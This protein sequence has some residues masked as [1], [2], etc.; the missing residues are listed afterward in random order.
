MRTKEQTM[1]QPNEGDLSTTFSTLNVNAMEFVPS[2][3]SSQPS[4]TP[5]PTDEPT[6]DQPS[7]TADVGGDDNDATTVPEPTGTPSEDITTTTATTTELIEDKTPE[8]P[9]EHVVYYDSTR[10]RSILVEFATGTNTNP[11][12]TDFY[13]I[14][15]LANNLTTISLNGDRNFI[16]LT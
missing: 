16:L 6:P 1:A 5:A 10:L 7:P 4:A 11:V 3:C 2:F 14:I 15:R 13:K 12:Q 9:G 8:N